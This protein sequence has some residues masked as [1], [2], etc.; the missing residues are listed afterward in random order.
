[1]PLT[2]KDWG[3]IAVLGGI[4]FL[5]WWYFSPGTGAAVTPATDPLAAAQPG[6]PDYLSYN[7]PKTDATELTLPGVSASTQTPLGGTLPV[8][9]SGCGC[10]PA[11]NDNFTAS[12]NNLAD[13]FNASAEGFLE[14]Y[15]ANVLSSM[16]QVF[17]QYLGNVYGAQ[18]SQQASVSLSG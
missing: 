16:P 1:M 2:S 11:L 14:Q 15:Q 9:S 5:A 18:L 17:S 12:L 8:A 3:E 7:F 6:A 4:V 13:E 10:S